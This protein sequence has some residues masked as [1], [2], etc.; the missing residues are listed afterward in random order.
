[1]PSE[2]TPADAS[3]DVADDACG[4][5]D[6]LTPQQTADL[7]RVSIKTL[8]NWRVSGRGLRFVRVGVRIRYVRR[9]VLD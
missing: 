9:H 8:A 2:A 6:L 4:V 1:M 7:L 5:D 3:V